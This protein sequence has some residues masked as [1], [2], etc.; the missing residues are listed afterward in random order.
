MIAESVAEAKTRIRR[1]LLSARRSVAESVRRTEA[2]QLCTHLA[3]AIDSATTVCAYVPMGTESGDER[4]LDVLAES[5]TT[6]LLPIARTG[7]AG[8]HLPLMFGRYQP[9]L[10]AKGPF[11][12]LE[13]TGPWLP[14]STLATADVVLVPALAVDRR[15][16][17]LGRGGGFYDRSLPL[18]AAGARLIAVVR[19]DEVLDELPGDPHDVPM[20]H[21]LTP[22]GGLLELGTA[23]R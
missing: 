1:E 16:V 12:F 5:V 9:G 4:M 6:V 13:P 23:D 18:C 19:D 11:G 2:E 14:T 15:G 3:A 8:Q 17:R 7:D 20:T 22:R 21:A 10:L